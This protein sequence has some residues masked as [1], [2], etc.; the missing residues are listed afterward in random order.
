MKR[1]VTIIVSC[2]MFASCGDFLQEYSKELVYANSCED[3][4][5]VMIGSGYMQHNLTSQFSFDA[6]KTS[7]DY[8]TWLYVMDDDLEEFV[9]GEYNETSLSTSISNLRPFYGWQQAPF[10]DVNGVLFDEGNWK[11]LYEH[12]GYLNVIIAQVKEFESDPEEMRRRITGE[13]QFLR[14]ACYYLLVNMYAKPYSRATA[15]EDPGVPLNVTEMIEDKYFSRNTVAEVYEQITEDLKNAAENLKGIGQSTIYRVNE[16]AAR[17]LLSRVYLYMGEWQL[18]LNEC[19]KAIALG[20]PLQDLNHFDMTLKKPT[21]T[22]IERVQYMNTKDS[23][24]VIFT[25]GS[26]VM[27]QLMHDGVAGR[28]A[29]SDE[30]RELYMRYDAE[31][32]EDLRMQAYFLVSLKDNTRFFSRKTPTNIKDITT[33]DGFIIRT[34]EAWLNKA[35]AEAM[36]GKAEAQNTLATLLEN[37]FK[38]GVIPSAMQGLSGE[39]LVRL[40]RDERRRELCFECQRWF[41]LRRYAV[42][43][44]YPESKEITHKVY[45]PGSATGGAGVLMGSYVLKPYGQDAAWMLPI[46]QYEI[47]YN[48]GAM[49]Q[50]EERPERPIQ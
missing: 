10:Q 9:T 46:P 49:K 34:A 11:K 42:C 30:L 4:D 22:T 39:S 41:D 26:N 27:H 18:A 43:E 31:G 25:Q 29:I 20:C 36:L 24:E 35:E 13:A 48:Q 6:L 21:S 47:S 1:I 38:D 15:G 2:L 40:I 17:I 14:G 50:N 44:K 3:L 7:K 45:G 8:Y 33:F 32:T 16:K 28:Y 19:D 5:E 37:R 12:I 23:P